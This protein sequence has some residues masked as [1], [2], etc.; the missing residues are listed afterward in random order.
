MELPLCV[1]IQLWQK[2][3]REGL[4]LPFSAPRQTN[5][6]P[7][8]QAITI[9]KIMFLRKGS[10][11]LGKVSLLRWGGVLDEEWL[12]YGGDWTFFPKLLQ[13]FGC[14]DKK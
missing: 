4:E 1:K 14:D 8:I 12:H 11:I 13:K 5:P 2:P 6:C 3:L 9:L 10:R 7:G